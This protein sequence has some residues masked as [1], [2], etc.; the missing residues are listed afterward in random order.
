MGGYGRDGID[1]PDPDP[2][3]GR[4]GTRDKESD[5]GEGLQEGLGVPRDGGPKSLGSDTPVVVDVGPLFQRSVCVFVWR[6]GVLVGWER[7]TKNRDGN[8]GVLLLCNLHVGGGW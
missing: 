5:Q 6:P 3:R 1:T 4:V 8:T 2:D 7:R